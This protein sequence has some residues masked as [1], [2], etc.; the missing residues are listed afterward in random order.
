MKQSMKN[1][2]LPLTAFL[3]FISACSKNGEDT[4]PTKTQLLT[5]GNWKFKSAVA[6]GSDVS[7]VIQ[8]CQKDNILSFSTNLSGNVAEG[9]TKCN[10][11]DPDN[12]PFTWAFASAE[13]EI[14][15]SSPLFTNG[16]TTFTLISLTAAEL[17]VQMPYNPP[18]GASILMTI[19]FNH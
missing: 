16:G 10:S 12:N 1:W 5:S 3:I 19:T 17:V 8:A 14:T 13:T 9:A 15:V 2:I 7:G 11:G 4:P 6:N 18:V